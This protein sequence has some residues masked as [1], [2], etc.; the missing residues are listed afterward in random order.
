MIVVFGSINVDVVMHV[1]RYPRAGET[2]L[3]DACLLRPGGKG[4]NQAVAAACVGASVRMFGAVGTDS[5]GDDM[6]RNLAAQ[7]VDVS[8][9][10]RV[11]Q[12]MTGCATI[13]V[14]RAGENAIC[15]GQGANLYARADA[16]P[17][18]ALGAASIVLAQMEV[19]EAENWA[20]LERAKARGARTVL[21]LA[22]APAS[23]GRTID[24][25]RRWVDVLAVNE[26]EANAI[27]DHLALPTAEPSESAVAIAH[28]L[29]VT[30][31]VTLG[32]DGASAVQGGN[33]IRAEALPVEVVDTTGAGDTFV[34]VLAAGLDR[35]AALAEA[36]R[37]ASVAGS[38]AC[39]TIGAQ[40]AM[41]DRATLAE[42][43]GRSSSEPRA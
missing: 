33:V 10:H 22:P 24:A 14:D 7:G 43:L 15:V 13:T 20:V 32:R 40:A 34:G 5:F 1:S 41:P 17:D 25:I 19:P 11:A 31:V 27:A 9:V 29:D 28:A 3:G 6:R 18:E 42:A 8:G 37:A 38:L 23:S 35:G 30:V 26:T 4:A 16:V 39:R 21:N 36:L 12:A 2:I